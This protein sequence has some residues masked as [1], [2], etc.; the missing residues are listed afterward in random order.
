VQFGK[1]GPIDAII[2]REQAEAFLQSM[3]AN[4]KIRR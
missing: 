3:S 1:G 2:K 4:E